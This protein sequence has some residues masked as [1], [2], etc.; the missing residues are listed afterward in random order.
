LD[1]Y[2]D[3]NNNF[4]IRRA[5]NRVNK[6]KNMDKNMDKGTLEQEE[7]P[8]K[9]QEH[10]MEVLLSRNNRDNHNNYPYDNKHNN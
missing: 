10:S 2:K 4:G 7:E 5:N 8:D 9:E 6:D 1:S 3:C